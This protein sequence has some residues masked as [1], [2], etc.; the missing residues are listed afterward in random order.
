M[1]LTILRN[2]SAI[3]VTITAGATGLAD[4]VVPIGDNHRIAGVVIPAVWA[5]AAISWQFSDDGVNFKDAWYEDGVAVSSEILVLAASATV[6]KHLIFTGNLA[7]A[8]ESPRYVKPRSGTSASPVNQ[9]TG[10]MLTI[11]LAPLR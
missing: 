4:T 6:N 5:A 1:A 3:G 7:R 10:P 9:T 8:M 2:G 11:L